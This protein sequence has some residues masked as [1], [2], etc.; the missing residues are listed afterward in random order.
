MK[1]LT[2]AQMA[3]ASIGKFDK[4][5]KREPDA[6]KSQKKEKKKSNKHLG[7]LEVN[8]G[9]EQGRNMKIFSMM[10][11]KADIST[12]PV[13]EQSKVSSEG[14]YKKPKRVTSGKN[15]KPSSK[16]PR[17]SVETQGRKQKNGKK[18]ATGSGKSVQK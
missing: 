10:N 14:G 8:R 4:K 11:K 13:G 6:P 5:L 16:G 2:M 17:Q 9:A 12:L 15:R 3:T 7:E 18:Q 1:S